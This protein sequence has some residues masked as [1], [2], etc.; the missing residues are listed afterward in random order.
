M[1]GKTGDMTNELETMKREWYH[2]VKANFELIQEIEASKRRIIEYNAM[3]EHN[4]KTIEWFK[5]DEQ[6]FF[7]KA[8]KHI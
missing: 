7:L 8:T 6:L 1:P 5:N 2:L 4:K 3:L